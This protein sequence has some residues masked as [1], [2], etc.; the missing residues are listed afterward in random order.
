VNPPEISV[1]IANYNRWDLM[2]RAVN[3]VL[4]QKGDMGFELLVVDDAS[5]RPPQALYQRV[6]KAGHRVLLGQQRRGPGPC[7]N[8]GAREAAG[9]YL[10]FLDSDDHWLAGKLER[11]WESLR[12]SGLRVGQ[13]QEIWYRDG[14][15]VQPLKAHR[16]EGGDQYQR[17]LH[18]V[19]VSP[20]SV[21]VE[22]DLFWE[23]GGFDPEL[24]VCEDYDLWLRVA[25]R[26]RFDMVAEELV[27]K[28]GGHG[29]QL[30]KALPAM[31][32]FRL[33][34]LAKG[35][36]SGA[37][38]ARWPAASRELT[39]KAEILAKGSAKRGLDSAVRCCS[40]L[41]QATRDG[42][43]EEV[44]RVSAELLHLWPVRPEDSGPLEISSST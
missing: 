41:S 27:V 29:D 18:Q 33:R 31:D 19:C 2:E 3:S 25:A 15:R 24:F 12:V 32:R 9:R 5:Q 23:V 37:Y 13:V 1:I 4:A 20:S 30:S 6:Q 40:L 28:L 10:A 8:W 43:W 38:G 34:A 42:R 44:D 14:V 21:M 16:V 35:L 11:Q 17:S 22:R 26:E 36:A 7:R 39:R